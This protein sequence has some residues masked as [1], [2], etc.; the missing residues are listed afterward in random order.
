MVSGVIVYFW[1]CDKRIQRAYLFLLPWVNIIIL[2]LFELADVLMNKIFLDF[3]E[4]HLLVAASCIFLRLL[5]LVLEFSEDSGQVI[6]ERRRLFEVWVLP[7]SAEDAG[8]ALRW[9]LIVQQSHPLLIGQHQ[10]ALPRNLAEGTRGSVHRPIRTHCRNDRLRNAPPLLLSRG[11]LIDNVDVLPVKL[12]VTLEC[13][14]LIEK[15]DTILRLYK[16]TDKIVD[17]AELFLGEQVLLE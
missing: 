7:G 10:H 12:V 14:D 9:P 17:R 5:L 2:C 8:L 16:L 11:L 6:S 1:E 4:R 13:F 15:D 3:G